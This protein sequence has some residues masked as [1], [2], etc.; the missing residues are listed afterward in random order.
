MSVCSILYRPAVI[1]GK[2]LTWFLAGPVLYPFLC[3]MNIIGLVIALQDWEAPDRIRT[4][5]K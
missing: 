4:A 5:L 3:G 2:R 1:L